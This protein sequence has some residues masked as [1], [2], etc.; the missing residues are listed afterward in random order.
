MESALPGVLGNGITSSNASA[1]FRSCKLHHPLQSQSII[2]ASGASG[3]AELCCRSMYHQ[4][5]HRRIKILKV[6]LH[7]VAPVTSNRSDPA[8]TAA[9]NFCFSAFGTSTIHGPHGFLVIVDQPHVKRLEWCRDS[10][11][12]R[13]TRSIKMPDRQPSETPFVVHSAGRSPILR[14]MQ[15]P[16][17]LCSR[18]FRLDPRS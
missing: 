2:P 8:E 15:T 7:S 1:I 5:I 16:G 4:V 11:V 6:R 9:D 3:T 12:L 14:V 13:I 18:I 10:H 17:M